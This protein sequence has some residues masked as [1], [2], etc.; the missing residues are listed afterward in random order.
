MF[1]GPIVLMS[2]FYFTHTPHVLIT[3]DVQVV[4]TVQSFDPDADAEVGKGA[5]HLPFFCAEPRFLHENQIAF[6]CGRCWL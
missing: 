4:A 6:A 1:R 5:L 2:R 3:H